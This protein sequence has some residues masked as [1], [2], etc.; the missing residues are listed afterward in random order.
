MVKE[1]DDPTQ[2]DTERRMQS[3]TACLVPQV[4]AQSYGE[5]TECLQ[6]NDDNIDKCLSQGKRMMSCWGDFC[7]RTFRHNAEQASIE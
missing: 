6:A 5:F 3:N 2:T 4:C 7:V 1:C